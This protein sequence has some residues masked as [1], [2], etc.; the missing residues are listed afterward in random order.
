MKNLQYELH[1]FENPDYPIIFHYNHLVRDKNTVSYHWHM[2][3]EILF[4]KIGIIEVEIDGTKCYASK[5]DI[6]VI[7]SNTIH[8]ISSYTEDAYYYCLIIDYK[9]CNDLGFDTIT[10]TFKNI[11]TD[12]EMKNIYQLIINES[13]QS[14]PHY[15][16]AVRA[17]CHTMLILLDRN[18][19]E[20]RS[21][22]VNKRSKILTSNIEITKAV[23]EYIHENYQISFSLDIMAQHIA[24]S[25]YHMCRI[26]KEIT[27]ITINGYTNQVRLMKARILLIDEEL[28]VS[29]VAELTGYNSISYFTK[30]FRSYFGYPPSQSKVQSHKEY[31][32]NKNDIPLDTVSE[33]KSLVAKYL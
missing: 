8:S 24:I 1:Y 5:G 28:T 30:T 19:V 26:F 10:T 31:L 23:I 15:K 3:I 7:N 11:N 16:K 14:K 4:V 13:F 29:E 9:F 18:Q 25:K 17:L 12:A 33:F 22:P 32:Q 21:L 20:S 2:N 6:V 27:S